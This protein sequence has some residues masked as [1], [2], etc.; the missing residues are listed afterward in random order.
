MELLISTHRMAAR[1]KRNDDCESLSRKLKKC[2]TVDPSGE[3]ISCSDYTLS[4]SI[5][6]SLPKGTLLI[7]LNL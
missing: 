3:F 7:P 6:V 5:I 2:L 1:I 4:N